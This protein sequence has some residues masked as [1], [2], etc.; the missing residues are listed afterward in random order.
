MTEPSS[1]RPRRSTRHRTL[2]FGGS[3]QARFFVG[4]ETVRIA[5]TGL[6][7]RQNGVCQAD[8]TVGPAALF[9]DADDATA[10]A[11]PAGPAVALGGFCTGA[12][13]A[14]L[15]Q[16]AFIPGL[17]LA[18]PAPTMAQAAVLT[19]LGL[20]AAHLP[21]AAPRRFARLLFSGAPQAAAAP[22]GPN[23]LVLMARLRDPPATTVPFAAAILPPTTGRRQTLRNR[24]S[25]AAWLRAR[26]V[27]LL[28]PDDENFSAL[29]AALARTTLLIIADPAQAGLL[30][31]CPPGTKI[32]EI[33]P[34]GWG[35]AATRGFADALGMDW[36]LFLGSALFYPLSNPMPFGAATALAYDV[37]I[38]ALARAMSVM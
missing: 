4:P 23:Y 36:S 28:N 32:L 35:N 25:L 13:A 9:C 11:L 20:D 30:G 38:Q 19:R 37:P 34:E 17:R 27:R 14:C 15:A 16:G 7:L 6:A 33:A 31:L 24:N 2:P 21:L 10:C 8:G 3:K 1:D 18:G 5:E 29:A 26:R 22:A 12:L